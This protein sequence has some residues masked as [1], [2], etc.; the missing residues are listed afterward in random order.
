[1]VQLGSNKAKDISI[2]KLISQNKHKEQS[3]TEA[4]DGPR[5]AGTDWDCYSLHVLHQIPLHSS[6]GQFD[7]DPHLLV[8][9]LW[10]QEG[11]SLERGL[12]ETPGRESRGRLLLP[13]GPRGSLAQGPCLQAHP[14]II[15]APCATQFFT[16]NP[17]S[18]PDRISCP[19]LS[20]GLQL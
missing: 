14:S 16:L 6:C 2:K 18:S 4:L 19:A 11:I 8:R 15:L 9:E 17:D 13:W 1:M 20:P 10:P 12:T 3:Q 7:S 5:T